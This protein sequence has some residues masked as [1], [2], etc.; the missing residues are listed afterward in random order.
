ME[1]DCND[2]NRVDQL[3]LKMHNKMYAL[4][5]A[6]KKEEEKRKEERIANGREEERA[7]NFKTIM[8]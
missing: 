4:T 7:L 1:E 6:E 3:K 2:W 5:I 8:S